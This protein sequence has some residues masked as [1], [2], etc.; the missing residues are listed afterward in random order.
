MRIMRCLELL[1]SIKG[2][3]G[4]LYW[5]VFSKGLVGCARR[6]KKFFGEP[7]LRQSALAYQACPTPASTKAR[8]EC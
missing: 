4:A 5:I 8:A 6:M 3:P 7:K 1:K 2:P